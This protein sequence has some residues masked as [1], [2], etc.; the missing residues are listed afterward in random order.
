MS[1]SKQKLKI[2]KNKQIR[3]RIAPSPTGFLHIGT[4]RTALF[5]F[6]FAKKH[7]GKFILR[8][9][10]TDLERSNLE[11][12]KDITEG[13]GW[14][15]LH[16]DEGINTGGNF[17]PYRQSERSKIYS[18]YI[19]QLLEKELAYHCFCSHEE[20]EAMKQDQ[21]SRGEEP[22]YT[23]KCSHLSKET[24][25]KN[26]QENKN[27]ILRF[28]MPSKKVIF[29][30][31]IRGKLEFETGLMGDIA[32]A[33]NE[34][35]PL[36]NLAA[37]IDD[38]TMQISH[39]IRGEDHLS[40]TP[41]QLMLQGVFGFPEPQYAH[42]PLILGPDRSKLSKRHEAVSI[43]EYK[44]EGFLPEALINFMALL[45]WN[46]GTE[47]EFFTLNELIEKFELLKVQKSGAVFNIEK[48]KWF[49]THYTHKKSPSELMKL[50]I[51][52]LINGK[53][54]K[55]KKDEYFNAKTKEKIS[56]KELEKIISL[57]GER[58]KTLEDITS[59]SKLFFVEIP[60]YEKELLRWKQTDW[61]VIKQ[62]LETIKETLNKVKSDK[63]TKDNL[64]KILMEDSKRLGVGETLWPLRVA[65]SGL[66]ASPGPHE[67]MDVLGKEKSIKRIEY[68]LSK[69]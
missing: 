5:N 64:H 42:L 18:N 58:M 22:R 25:K 62:N 67:I 14:L 65:L 26:L 39:V 16:W 53:L 35:T 44:N 60:D 55:K 63:F 50:T 1:T 52:Y 46:P 45:G 9:E 33:R 4:A 69:L 20:L 57:A 48:L 24:V 2:P 41:K 61:P 29:Q 56:E 40:N 13:L 11:F 38:Y 3:V 34:K 21:L 37:V 54:L 10:D 12:E 6:L 31:L 15:G 17:G 43:I 7:G 51:P 19:N 28:K 8:I 27:F 36:Y 32:I 49:N 68:A 59:L 47:Q 30:D 66:K 23:G